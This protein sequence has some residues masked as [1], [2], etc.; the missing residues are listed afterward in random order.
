MS[1]TSRRIAKNAGFLMISQVMTWGMTLVI[2]I[3]MTRRLGAQGVGQIHLANSIWAIVAIMVAFGMDTL[4]TKEIARRPEQTGKMFSTSALLRLGLHVVG[5][6]VVAGYVYLAGYGAVTV[7]VIFLTGVASLLD[8]FVR[9]CRASLQGLETMEFITLGDVASRAF[10]LVVT[11]ALLLLGYGVVPVVAV[12]AGAAL[13][14]LLIQ[15]HFLRREAPLSLAFDWSYARSMLKAGVPYLMVSIFLVIYMQIDIIII[16]LLVDERGVGWYGA[17]D[18]LFGTLLFVP[19]VFVTAVFPTLSRMYASG[20][21]SVQPIMSKSFDLLMLLS[22][23]IGLGVLLVANQ[24]V[25]LLFGSD[26]TNSGPILA[27]M[28][29]VL[30]LTYQNMLLG[31][32]LI[33]TD[34]QNQW[35]WVMGIATVATIPLDLVL[36]PWCQQMFG[37]GA[38]GGA[39]AFVVTESGM[40]IAGIGMLPAGALNRG[41]AWRAA[42]ILLAG[43]AMLAVTW[44]VRDLFLVVPVLVGTAVYLV[45]ILLLRVV[46]REDWLLLKEAGLRLTGRLRRRTVPVA[47]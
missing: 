27:V 45:A 37:N 47:N 2:L 7:A 44:W 40:L 18:Q 5:T 24:T 42:R 12:G 21:S 38:I 30:I 34:R 43:L 6:A 20:S 29:I 33:S 28:G 8:Q 26:F 46:P 41:N 31:Q 10:T 14:N 23:P 17:A 16:S 1:S 15:L 19:T 32:F 39:L 3:F 25:T 22:V 36:I 13:L 4:L 11:I 35:T 9:V